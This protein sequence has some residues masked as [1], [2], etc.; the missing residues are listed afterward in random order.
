MLKKRKEERKYGREEGRGE[1]EIY[2]FNYLYYFELSLL[3]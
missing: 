3:K 2:L 1:R